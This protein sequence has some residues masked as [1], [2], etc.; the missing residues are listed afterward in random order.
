MSR[1]FH[2]PGDGVAEQRVFLATPAYAGVGAGYAESLFV[3]AQALAQAGIASELAI[4][5]G[6]CHVDDARNR[7]VREFL[8]TSCTDLVFLDADMGWLPESL[9]A[10]CRYDR[11]VVAATYPMRS[12]ETHFPVRVLPG[13]IWSDAEGLIEVEGVPAGFLRIRRRVLERLGAGAPK[14]CITP[15]SP[16]DVPVI[17]ERQIHEGVRWGGDYV[18]CRKWRAAGGKVYVVPDVVLEHTG[19]QSFSGSLGAVLRVARDAA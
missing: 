5:S 17:F 9:V 2:R 10:L 13:P 3:S 11:D 19:Q 1:L 6:Y 8:D 15:G 12:A 4:L 16:D 18:F 14:V 7:L